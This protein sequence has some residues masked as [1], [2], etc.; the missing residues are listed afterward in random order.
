MKATFRRVVSRTFERQVVRL[1]RRHKLKVIAV[2]GSVG[3]TSTRAAIVTVLRHKYQTQNISQPGYNSEIGLPLS[4]FDFTVPRMMLNP[5]AWAWLLLRSEV[6]IWSK[7]PHQVLVLELGI[8]HPGEMQRYLRYLKPD[9][10]VM[11]AVTPEHMENFTGLDAVAAEE[12]LLAAKSTRFLANHDDVPSQVRRRYIQDHPKH[13]YYGLDRQVAYSA[14][15]KTSDLIEG[16]CCSFYKAA[17]EV[18]KDQIVHT[19]GPS[20]LKSATAAFAVGDLM[21][22]TSGQIERGLEQVRPIRGRMN[23]LPG[24]NE[25]TIIDDTYNSSPAAAIASLQALEDTHA[26]GRKIAILGSMNELGKKGPEYH[27]E[28]GAA[29]AGVD[30]LVTIGELA[31]KHLGPAALEAGLDSSK[32]KPSDSPYAA[33]RYARL[34][35]SPHDVVLVKGSQDRVFAEEAVKQLLA[36]PEDSDELVRQSDPW[37]ATKVE[38]FTDAGD[39]S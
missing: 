34:L 2:A 29:A 31:N 14:R 30:L 8:D 32:F 5:I 27:E 18:I 16:T 21:G 28:V 25:S 10:G 3:K 38:L 39:L 24:L 22:M 36:R 12:M 15:L 7:Y 19:Y 26:N 35:L 1:I 6:I 20:S 17:H 33:G 4:V 13:Y 9:L 37:M 11:T 23:I